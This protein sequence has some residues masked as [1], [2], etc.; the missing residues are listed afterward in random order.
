MCTQ[1]F[2]RGVKSHDSLLRYKTVRRTTLE[3]KYGCAVIINC[4]VE[5]NTNDKTE[6]E[7]SQHMTSDK[8]S[9]CSGG[10]RREEEEQKTNGTSIETLCKLL[11]DTH[12]RH[13]LLY[14]SQ[15]PK[16]TISREMLLDHLVNVN[17]RAK[18]GTHR[19]QLT[20]RLHHVHLPMLA[21]HGLIEYDKIANSISYTAEPG[22]EKM[23]DIVRDIAYE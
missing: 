5:V 17:D 9:K 3:Q 18:K 7:H 4:P 1:S 13:I 22:V 21:D 11:S 6:M 23:L 20:V 19:R 15:H 2:L 10:I 16:A 14:L 12:R 8:P